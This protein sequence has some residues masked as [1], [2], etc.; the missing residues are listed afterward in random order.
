MKINSKILKELKKRKITAIAHDSRS[1]ESGSVFFV[2]EGKNFDIFSC[3]P[4]IEKKVALFIVQKKN[5]TKFNSLIR[6]KP[7]IFVNDI[8]KI[9]RQSVDWFY[10]FKSSDFKFVGV[11][12][13]NGKTTI[14]TLVYYFLKS[15]KIR[16]SLIGTVNY[17][18]GSKKVKA[19]HTTPD[20][21]ALRK[22]FKIANSEK[23]KFIIMEVSSHAIDQNRVAGIDFSVCAFT[24]LTRDHLD[25][26]KTMKSY[27]FAKKKLFFSNKKAKA[28]INNDDSYGR[29]LLSQLNEPISYGL[30]SGVDFKAENISLSKENSQF[31]LVCKSGRISVL[32]SLL[33]RHNICNI[34]AAGAIVSSLGFS[35]KSFVRFIHS[36]RLVNGR[37][38]AVAADIFLDYAHTP[39]AL[40]RVLLSLREIGYKKIICC[41]GCG[42]NRDKGKRARMG[43]IADKYADFTI[44]TSDNPRNE[45]SLKIISDIERGFTGKNYM[46]VSDRK[47]A[48]AKAIKVKARYSQACLLVAGKGHEKYQIIGEKKILFS[49]KKVIKKYG[50]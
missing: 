30:K 28:I 2:L 23:V 3:L 49:D 31:D 35:L 8:E 44:I 18:I 13:T 16:S 37:M 36:F 17:L 25:Y 46:I 15:I 27:F 7:V 41:F 10:N 45:N 19:E 38:E 6:K 22:L 32:T 40:K 1:V 5:K 42:G 29:V 26:H 4:S 47:A 39:D 48:I 20:Y 9:Y 50:N 21:L 24:N 33:G 11:T 43:K 14:T 34:L 12:G